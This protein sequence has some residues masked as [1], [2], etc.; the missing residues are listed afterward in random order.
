M[1]I[2]FEYI[3]EKIKLYIKVFILT[4]LLFFK[5]YK[6]SFG[7]NSF[8]KTENILILNDSSK[9]DTLSLRILKIKFYNIK[10]ESI[11]DSI[12]YNKKN[13]IKQ[14][15]TY[16]FS[17]KSVKKVKTYIKGKL[18]C[19]IIEF[20]GITVMITVYYKNGKEKYTVNG[21]FM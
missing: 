3:N 1:I 13:K 12:F 7:I 15:I 14:S 19:S 17:D 21:S 18:R 6:S 4:Y 20:I 2:K 10:F 11:G 8:N 16:P 9:I 5:C